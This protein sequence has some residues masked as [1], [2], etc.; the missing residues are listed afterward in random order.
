[1]R[2]LRVLPVPVLLETVTEM[3]VLA[4]EPE[5][6][7]ALAVIVCAALEREVVLRLKD[8]L[9]VPEAVEKAPPSTC[10]A[11]ELR[12]TESEA[13]PET[14]MVPETVAS[15]A[16]EE[17]AAEG[18][19]LTPVPESAIVAGEF[20][21]SLTSETEPVTE[22]AEE[23]ANTTVKVVLEPAARVAGEVRPVKL[24][25]TPETVA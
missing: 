20:D 1:M 22:P 6:S 18:F 5:V 10:T 3:E 25:P 16:G 17:I 2:T 15:L 13:V 23:G 21:A 19:G 11:T 8:Q 12:A 9:E 14:V 4:V 7:V 24:K